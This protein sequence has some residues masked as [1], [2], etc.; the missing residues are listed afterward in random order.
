VP[1]GDSSRVEFRENELRFE[2]QYGGDARWV[3]RCLTESGDLVCLLTGH[4]SGHA[5]VFRKINNAG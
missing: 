2:K 1:T 5:V 4:E 3:Y